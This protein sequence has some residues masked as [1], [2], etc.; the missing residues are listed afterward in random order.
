MKQNKLLYPYWRTKDIYVR[1]KKRGV[2]PK[3][4]AMIV[5]AVLILAYLF[6]AAFA[7]GSTST[8]DSRADEV[9]SGKD[10]TEVKDELNDNT[11]SLLSEIDFSNLQSFINSLD[12][13]QKSLFGGDFAAR[14]KSII[15]GDLAIDSGSLFGYISGLFGLDFLTYSSLIVTVLIAALGYNIATA[16]KSRAAGES[17]DKIVYFAMLTVVVTVAVS[18]FASVAYD[19]VSVVRAVASVISACAPILLT[20]MTAS[21]ATTTAAVYSPTVAVLTSGLVNLIT[22]VALPMIILSAVLSVI[23]GVSTTVKLGRIS[24]FFNSAVKW[25]LGTAFFVFFA[26]IGIQGITASVHDGISLRAAK[27][28][29]SK[30][31]P[32][33]G[34]YLSDGFNLVVAGNVLIKNAVGLSAV[35][36]ASVIVIPVI[37]KTVVFTL[38]LKLASALAEPLGGEKIAKTLADFSKSSSAVASAVIGMAFLSVIFLVMII[39]TGNLVL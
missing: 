39:S 31:V 7:I 26:I 24:E 25:L 20:V 21:G 3:T 36:L 22:L 9:G 30:Y 13:S 23:N 37:V 27:F 14:V 17:V 4:R 28:A 32:I 2:S 5:I 10:V 38:S 35:V 6:I 1:E 19:A 18:A 12:S 15:S 16:F 33:I 11:D 34:G 29:V 8:T